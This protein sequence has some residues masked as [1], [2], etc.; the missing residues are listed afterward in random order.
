MPGEMARLLPLILLA[1]LFVPAAAR[2]DDFTPTF[3]SC[4]ASAAVNG[5]AAVPEINNVFNLAISP[6]GRSAYAASAASDSL[7]IFDRDPVSGKLTAKACVNDAGDDGCANGRAMDG[8]TDVVVTADGKNVYVASNSAGIAIFDRRADGTL[9]ARSVREACLSF[10]GSDEGL[11]NAC[12]D[13]RGLGTS[14]FNGPFELELSPD[15]KNVYAGTMTGSVLTLD[16]QA[17]G[18]LTQ[19]PGPAGCARDDGTDDCFNATGLGGQ[20]RQ[21]AVSPDGR[22]VYVPALSRSGV[23]VFDRD[24]DGT[25]TQR[26]D[27]GRCITFNGLPSA[28]VE[29]CAKEPRLAGGPSTLAISADGRFLYVP[30]DDS[31]LTFARRA[32]GSLGFASCINDRGDDGCTAGRGMTTLG[33]LDIAPDGEDIVVQN[34]FIPNGLAFLHRNAADGSLSQDP[35][36]NGC[37]T[38]SGGALDNGALV[39]GVCRSSSAISAAGAVTFASD[40]LLYAASPFASTIVTLKR[41]FAPRCADQ[42]LTAG[43]ESAVAVPLECSDR[44]GDALTLQ[45]AAQPSAGQLGA[46]DAAG[47]RVF[48]NPFGGF[49]GADSFKYRAFGGGQT[50]NTAVV[51]LQVAAAPPAAPSGLDGDRDGFF[52]GQDCN[53]ANPAI[54]P[55]ALELRGNRVDE[56]CDGLAEPFPTVTSGVSAKWDINGSRFKLTQLTISNPPNRAKFEFRCAG[57]AC[58]L[59]SKKLTGKVRRGLLNVRPSLGKKLRYRA[60]QT[61]EVRISASGFNT[62]VAQIK[63]R[64]GKT[65]SVVALCLAPGA[66]RPQKTC[67]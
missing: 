16:R 51:S 38:A 36:V 41:D 28:G 53:D 24:A 13:V 63:L 22:N 30:V 18:A 17:S 61:I 15:G 65:P 10:D 19:R 4:V 23:V 5:C 67:T 8:A 39:N 21:L 46:I 11:A 50:S 49:T 56:N 47:A 55:G 48:Y 52:A 44:N 1:L 14:R 25:L 33:Y 60:G 31:V 26:S 37:L 59:K 6:D 12:T 64:A 43:F 34:L 57:L 29:Q 3:Q 58:P 54:R 20:V 2:A 66:A 7:Q 32:D 35:G 9:Q 42:S 62:K 40:S 45:I 27:V